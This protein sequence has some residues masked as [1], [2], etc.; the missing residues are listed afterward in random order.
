[1]EPLHPQKSKL[2]SSGCLV[3]R[4]GRASWA[5]TAGQL[6]HL[7]DGAEPLALS[8]LAWGATW[9][10]DREQAALAFIDVASTAE[11][12]GLVA[13]W[14]ESPEHGCGHWQIHVP[15]GFVGPNEGFAN[16]TTRAK[17]RSARRALAKAIP[18]EGY[19]GSGSYALFGTGGVE[20]T[21]FI[22]QKQET[23]DPD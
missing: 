13:T 16:R 2:P 19:Q 18:P 11:S 8:S 1:M 10:V 15:A 4:P 22:R 6:K 17:A 14:Q 21:V 12:V 9:P 3:S 5:C 23:N 20:V 7:L